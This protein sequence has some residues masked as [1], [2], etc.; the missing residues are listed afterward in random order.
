M[1][2]RNLYIR[3]DADGRFDPDELIEAMDTVT[4][5]L[6]FVGG[7]VAMGVNRV[8]YEPGKFRAD[9]L[10][11]QYNTFVPAQHLETE[12]G[13]DYSEPDPGEEEGEDEV[14]GEAPEPVTLEQ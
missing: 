4:T 12:E 13:A 10:F 7:Q 3:A 8:E 9:G 1:A 14:V 11:I 2:K 6:T 5:V